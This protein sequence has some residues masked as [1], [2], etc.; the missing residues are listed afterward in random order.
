MKKIAILSC[1]KSTSVCSGAACF[2]AV[3]NR[4]ASFAAYK[5]EEV[6]IV[7]FFHCNGCDCKYENDESYREKIER[8]I[9]IKPYAVHVGLCT[10]S[11]G[12]E[13]DK[14]TQIIDKLEENHIKIVR[15]T[16]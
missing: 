11:K 15:G 14:I 7:A 9:S 16:H 13:C 8:V 10:I 4:E 6:S 5:G 12:I 1:L 3:N 2:E